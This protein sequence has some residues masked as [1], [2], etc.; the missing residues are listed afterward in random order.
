MRDMVSKVLR[1]QLA[2]ARTIHAST[3]LIQPVT[4]QD[5]LAAAEH[6][7]KFHAGMECCTEPLV[8]IGLAS[9]SGFPT[10]FFASDKHTP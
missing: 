9:M 10:G 4:V 7:K 8:I 3:K 1:R 2:L 5:G 6:V